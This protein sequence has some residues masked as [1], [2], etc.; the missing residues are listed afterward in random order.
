MSESSVVGGTVFGHMFEVLAWGVFVSLVAM[1][2]AFLAEGRGPFVL[3]VLLGLKRHEGSLDVYET[4]SR[5]EGDW[6]LLDGLAEVDRVSEAHAAREAAKAAQ[7]VQAEPRPVHRSLA[8][9][10]VR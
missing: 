10:T 9:I 2:F 6:Q 3:N 4:M 5:D 8:P 1:V 7:A